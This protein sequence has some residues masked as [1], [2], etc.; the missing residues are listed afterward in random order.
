M[1][2]GVGEERDAARC[3]T[4]ARRARASRSSGSHVM[5][6]RTMIRRK[7]RSS[8]GRIICVRRKNW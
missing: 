4:H 8:G 2:V 7:S 5:P 6:A 1:Q 3:P